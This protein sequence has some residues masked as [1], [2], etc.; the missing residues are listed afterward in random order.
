MAESYR[1][2]ENGRGMRAF[3]KVGRSEIVRHAIMLRGIAGALLLLAPLSACDNGTPSESGSPVA[4]SSPKEGEWARHGHDLSETRFS[5]LTEIGTANVANLKLAWFY[6]LDTN[7]GQES[8]PVMVDGK[9]F[10]TSARSEEHTSE[11]QSH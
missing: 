4:L 5:P 8:T 2:G 1:A 9:L 10:T 3:Q 6:D 11:L 7:R